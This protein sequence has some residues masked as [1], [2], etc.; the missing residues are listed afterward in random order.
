MPDTWWR[1][2]SFNWAKDVD[3]SLYIHDFNSPH[4]LKSQGVRSGDTGGPFV[5]KTLTKDMVVFI[6]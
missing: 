6:C 4:N 1:I 2:A 3:Q 5:Q